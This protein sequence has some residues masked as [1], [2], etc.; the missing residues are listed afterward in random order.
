M[1]RSHKKHGK[2]CRNLIS[3]PL[4][5][6]NNESAVEG[7]MV[8]THGTNAFR[9]RLVTVSI[10]TFLQWNP[11]DSTMF[12]RLHVGDTN[13]IFKIQCM[14]CIFPTCLEVLHIR[15]CLHCHAAAHSKKILTYTAGKSHIKLSPALV[16]SVKNLELNKIN[17]TQ[18]HTD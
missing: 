12:L 1:T 3:I 15:E 6:P 4:C 18:C 13:S 16:S 9:E 5:S 11:G 8:Q 10:G 2:I 7:E 17:K 14:W